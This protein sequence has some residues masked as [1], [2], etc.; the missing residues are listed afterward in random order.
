[1]S[2]EEVTVVCRLCL[3]N[4]NLLWVFDERFEN[5]KNMKDVIFVTTGV[6][7]SVFLFDK[8]ML[9]QISMNK[10]FLCFERHL[11]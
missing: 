8:F 1:M 5:T 9:I 11:L 6:E 7:V 10:T 3:K 4:E 2:V